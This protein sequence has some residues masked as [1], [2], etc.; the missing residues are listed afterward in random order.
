MN[1]VNSSD[2]KYN[3]I[4]LRHKQLS[5]DFII[6]RDSLYALSKRTPALDKTISKEV[7]NII[8]NLEKVF[9]EL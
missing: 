5:D 7:I 4:I 3:S 1:T 8:G 2:P 9:T 6:I